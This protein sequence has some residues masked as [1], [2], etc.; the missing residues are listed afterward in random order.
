[1]EQSASPDIVAFLQEVEKWIGDELDLSLIKEGDRVLVRTRNTSYLLHMTGTH[2]ARL[3][4]DRPDRPG[5]NAKIKGCAFG[6]SRMI[7]PGHLFCGGNMEFTLE[8]SRQTFLTSPIQA[9]QWIST[10]PSVPKTT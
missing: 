10:S 2:S 3:V 4:T 9:I 6:H 8:Q 5:G 1:M 7:K